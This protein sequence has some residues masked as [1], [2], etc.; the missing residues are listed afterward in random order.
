MHWIQPIIFTLLLL[1]IAIFSFGRY[2][3]IWHNIQRGKPTGPADQKPLRW[4]NMLLLAFG[5]KKMF[6]NPLPAI[7]HFFIYAAFVITQIELIEI[8]L[9]GI[10]GHHRIFA[11]SL[12]GFYTFIISF[13]EILSLLALV[14]TFVFLWRRN[15]RKVER[16]H[17]PELKGWPIK[18][19]NLILLGEFLLV[20]GIFTMNGADTVLQKMIPDHYPPTGNLA[21]SS[22]LGPALFSGLPGGVL[23]LLERAGWWLHVVVVLG[24][25]AY[26][27]V[28]KHLHI[29][30]AF[31]HTFFAGLQPRGEM[32]NM[33]A[34]QR[35]VEMMLDPAKATGEAPPAPA[36]FGAKDVEDLTR[37]Q[38]LSAYTCT[39]CGRCTAVCPANITGKL[40]SPRK[41]MMDVR[42][43]MEE[44]SAFEKNN[45]PGAKDEKSLLDRISREE[46]MACT[47]CN[48]CVEA[49]P[50]N[51]NPL[52]I[53]LDL[54]RYYILDEAKSPEEW[55]M[56]FSNIENNGAPWKFS[57]MDRANW[58]QSS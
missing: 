17:K 37:I 58:T 26:L 24:F 35:E 6:K 55:N 12:G 14:A 48:A 21:V 28:S 45:A 2:R 40:L 34:I 8:I 27:P 53:I 54:R 30:L 11:R 25:I 13:I 49:C 1:G 44:I 38:L 18:D 57:P 46:L 32:T 31:P 51:I 39:E 20:L 7:F 19:A 41:V 4:K 10:S 42:D 36:R 47:S 15:V 50:I 29:F 56:M 16:L 5:Q 33:P 52:G 43:R 22:W 9:D 23:H 3:Q